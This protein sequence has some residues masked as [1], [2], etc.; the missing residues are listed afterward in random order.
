M[1]STSKPNDR[2]RNVC[3]H[4]T[5]LHFCFCKYFKLSFLFCFVILSSFVCRGT[6]TK[7]AVTGARPS[8][9][10]VNIFLSSGQ[11]SSMHFS[12]ADTHNAIFSPYEA[13]H[14]FKYN[15]RWAG[16]KTGVL[17]ILYW[18]SSSNTWKCWEH[19]YF[20]LDI[21]SDNKKDKNKK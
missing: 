21:Y 11:V 14:C 15:F 6:L 5:H 12:E 2:S 1:R 4:V 8:Y 10:L 18:W 13:S 20:A 3:S 7:M 17:L 9:F 16:S 19:Q